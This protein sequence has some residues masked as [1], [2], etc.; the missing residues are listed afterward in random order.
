MIKSR[1]FKGIELLGLLLGS[2]GATSLRSEEVSA[3]AGLSSRIFNSQERQVDRLAI[4]RG[5]EFLAKRSVSSGAVACGA[6]A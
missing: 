3:S 1:G 5:L 6:R 4:E 2:L